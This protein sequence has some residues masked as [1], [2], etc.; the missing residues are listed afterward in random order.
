MN[1]WWRKLKRKV[2]GIKRFQEIMKE[3]GEIKKVR[4]QKMT[5]FNPYS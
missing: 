5:A 3:M 1:V 4:K 2:K